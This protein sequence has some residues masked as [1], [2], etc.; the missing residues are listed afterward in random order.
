ML[1]LA[2]CVG[3]QSGLQ[4]WM[5][6][7]QLI[8]RFASKSVVLCSGVARLLLPGAGSE[9]IAHSL[10]MLPTPKERQK[11]VAPSWPPHPT[12][13]IPCYTTGSVVRALAVKNF[14]DDSPPK[15]ADLFPRSLR[16][17]RALTQRPRIIIHMF[18]LSSAL[19]G[20]KEGNWSA[21]HTSPSHHA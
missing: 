18:R 19:E 15:R 12:P 13:F 6:R 3:Y 20:E 8:S 2:R 7:K 9:F 5:M 10:P 17:G 21:H 11:R 16:L 14:A 4:K 1:P